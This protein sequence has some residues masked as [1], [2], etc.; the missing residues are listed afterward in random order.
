MAQRCVAL[1]DDLEKDEIDEIFEP[2]EPLVAVQTRYC[3]STCSLSLMN[4]NVLLL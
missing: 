2:L 4:L 3:A 1:R